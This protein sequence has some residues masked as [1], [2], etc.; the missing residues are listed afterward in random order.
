MLTEKLNLCCNYKKNIHNK[1]IEIKLY[2]EK[3]KLSEKTIILLYKNNWIL[4]IDDEHKKINNYKNN[5]NL[6][7]KDIKFI[8]NKY[9]NECQ[10]NLWQLINYIINCKSNYFF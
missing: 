7:Y 8:S 2:H 9:K 10:I 3:I 5:I 4:P 1:I 6:L